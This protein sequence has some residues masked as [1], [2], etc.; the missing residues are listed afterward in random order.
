MVFIVL[1]LLNYGKEKPTEDPNDKLSFLKL[2]MI[3]GQK[4]TAF[5]AFKTASKHFKSAVKLLPDDYWQS[6][7]ELA[8]DLFAS[9]AE[10]EYAVPDFKSMKEFCDKILNKH[11]VSPANKLRISH[12]LID[13]CV[14]DYKPGESIHVAISLLKDCGVK[15]PQVKLR[16]RLSAAFGLLR[17]KVSKKMQDSDTISKLAL[18]QNKTDTE[19]MK[20]LDH[21]ATAAYVGKPELFPLVVLK[22][23]Q[24]TFDHGIT[25]YS[26]AAFALAGLLLSCFMGDLASGRKFAKNGLAKLQ[27][28]NCKEVESRTI[29]VA[30][31]FSEQWMTMKDCMKYLFQGYEVGLSTGDLISAMYCA[32]FWCEYAFYTGMPLADVDSNMT[33]YGEQLEDFGQLSIL[34]GLRMV[35]QAVRIT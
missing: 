34:S 18:T 24:Y 31:I 15:I 17:I 30:Y 20:T 33:N 9:A 11:S 19:T 2:H 22:S 7:H 35:H 25:I 3:A 16:I 4:A 8:L 1:G 29:F 32:H 21:L 14:A 23:I 26:P 10:A 6:H 13:A 27:R 28:V 12:V 5:S